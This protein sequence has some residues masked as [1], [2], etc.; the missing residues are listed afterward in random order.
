MMCA[1]VLVRITCHPIR[2]FVSPNNISHTPTTTQSNIHMAVPLR[3][4][5]TSVLAHFG[6]YAKSSAHFAPNEAQFGP[7]PLWSSP[8]SVLE[9]FN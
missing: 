7:C 5:P 8:T 4:Q 6:P 2:T 3:Y 1:L 9:L